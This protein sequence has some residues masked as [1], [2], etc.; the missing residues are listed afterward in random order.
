MSPCYPVTCQPD[1]P[2]PTPTPLP[3]CEDGEPCAEAMDAGCVIYT[4][5]PLPAVNVQPQ[6]RLND[7]I[8]KWALTVL[9]QTQAIATAPTN[10][11]VF[12]G[13]GLSSSP[14]AALVKLHPD[15]HNLIKK[16]AEG[17]IVK[18]DL[19]LL[20]DLATLINS[21]AEAHEL[22]C[23]LVA[24]C[25]SGHCGTAVALQV[26]FN[27]QLL[28]ATWTPFPTNVSSQN[29]QYKRLQD[30]QWSSQTNVH[31][32]VST[33]TIPTIYINSVY[34]VRIQTNCLIG[35]PSFNIPLT[36]ST[37]LCPQPHV[38][39]AY[40]RISYSF[41]YEVRD[42]NKLTVSLI[43]PGN[44]PIATKTHT[45]PTDTV[46]LL[47]GVFGD[48]DPDTTYHLLITMQTHLGD[49]Y[50]KSCPE[51]PVATQP[52]PSCS[53]PTNLHAIIQ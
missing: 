35:G 38:V 32:S 53:I 23:E 26:V 30:T 27:G 19:C 39:A 7:I 25:A 20:Q 4:N 9:S 46:Q 47:S 21:S 34:Q 28:Q 50:T 52:P 8:R 44:V 1:I 48:L 31:Y 42:Y 5:E 37:A 36:I 24:G 17:L 49:F 16:S 14:L 13:T 12:S 33:A 45:C 15:A 6:D 22:F 18:V 51:I 10:D 3:P 29:V 43:G 41:N 11:V 40:D 2:V